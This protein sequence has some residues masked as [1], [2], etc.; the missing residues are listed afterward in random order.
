MNLEVPQYFDATTHLHQEDSND[1]MIKFMPPVPIDGG[2]G[3]F[4]YEN[5]L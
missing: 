3:L 5:S 1:E 2:V 4:P